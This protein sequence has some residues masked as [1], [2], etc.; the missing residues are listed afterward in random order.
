MTSA[1]GQPTYAKVWPK[2]CTLRQT[3]AVRAVISSKEDNM[4]ALAVLVTMVILV[5]V[6]FVLAW[7]VTW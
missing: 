5:T 7:M 2:G 1:S 4:V 3:S 6:C